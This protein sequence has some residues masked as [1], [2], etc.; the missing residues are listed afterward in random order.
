[1][2]QK[3]AEI[4]HMYKPWGKKVIRETEG[5]TILSYLINCS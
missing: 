3:E 2:K 4:A 1:M 5:R